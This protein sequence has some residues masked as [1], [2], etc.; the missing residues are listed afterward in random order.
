MF[1][2]SP[3]PSLAAKRRVSLA[4]QFRLT[5][6]DLELMRFICEMKFAS[7]TNVYENFF[8]VLKTGDESKSRRWVQ[9][10]L[11]RI[12]SEGLLM[13]MFSHQIR[14]SLFVTTPKG[15]R[16]CEE[17]IS[18][19]KLPRPSFGI[20]YNT[21][22]HDWLMIR[23]RRALEK[24]GEARVWFSE[25]VLLANPDLLDG[26]S[27]DYFPDGVYEAPDGTLIAVELEISRKVRSLYRE[28]L[29]RYVKYMR[30]T[31]GSKTAIKS[32]TILVAKTAVRKVIEDE[33]RIFGDYFRILPLGEFLAQHQP[34]LKKE[35][36]HET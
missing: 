9:R 28:K 13:R 30:E 29:N 27:Q 35:K 24:S 31:N 25:R 2:P 34:Q 18:S 19:R 5:E 15:Y 1:I 22:D 21:F 14:E 36:S 3:V 4:R 12:E 8:K 6:R 17:V 16:V 33:A 23:I 20:N 26:F 10:R 11:R 7:T 32:V